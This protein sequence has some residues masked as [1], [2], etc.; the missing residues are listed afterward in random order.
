MAFAECSWGQPDGYTTSINPVDAE[1]KENLMFQNCVEFCSGTQATGMVLTGQTQ[2]YCYDYLPGKNE[3][4]QESDG[5]E[6]DVGRCDAACFGDGN[7]VVE[8]GCGGYFDGAAAIYS[9]TYPVVEPISEETPA[10][11]PTP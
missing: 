7:K 2:C 4:I 6:R 5:G 8:S 11:S 1:G 3:P 9:L 10:P